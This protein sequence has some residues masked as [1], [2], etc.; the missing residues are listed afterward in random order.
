[1]AEAIVEEFRLPVGNGH[2]V[3]SITLVPSHKGVF[4]VVADGKLVFSKHE[5][6]RHAEIK[7]VLASLRAL[8]N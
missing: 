7:E 3:E 5:S 1:L 2:G 4:D 6:G 8:T